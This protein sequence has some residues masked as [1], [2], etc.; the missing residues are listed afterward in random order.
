MKKQPPKDE[1]YDIWVQL[2]RTRR[3]IFKVREHELSQLGL[4]P[5]QAAFLHI[6][7]AHGDNMTIAQISQLTHREL[8]TVLGIINRMEHSGLVRKV[9]G[10]GRYN[11]IKISLTENGRKAYLQSI[12]R[13]RIHEIVAHLSKEEQKQLNSI[14]SKLLDKAHQLLQTKGKPPLPLSD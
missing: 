2:A 4:T 14:L 13:D 10:L 6:L 7:N 1:Y 8:H 5:H 9:K 11:V 3:V 12:G